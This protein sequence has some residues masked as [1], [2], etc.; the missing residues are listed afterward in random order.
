MYA[1][2]VSPALI[3]VTPDPTIV[4]LGPFGIT[5]YSLGYVIGLA[6]E[7]AEGEGE[8]DR[9]ADDVAEAQWI[10]D[11]INQRGGV[12]P[13]ALVEEV[14]ELHLDY[15]AGEPLQMDPD[16]M[17][18][19]EQTVHAPA[20]TSAGSD[21]G[22]AELHQPGSHRPAPVGGRATSPVDVPPVEAGPRPPGEPPGR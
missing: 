1:R 16:E 10:S 2:L 22:A 15:L 13:V 21:G 12:A 20:S 4:Q 7:L 3:M 14:L 8:H 19:A 5:W 18:V 11:T 9:Q 17:H 6:V